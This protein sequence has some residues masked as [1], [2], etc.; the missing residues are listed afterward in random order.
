MVKANPTIKND[1]VIELNEKDL[2]EASQN[3]LEAF[4]WLVKEDKKQNPDFY[5]QSNLSLPCK[6]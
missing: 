3:L 6:E 2:N 1:T 5:N 4:L